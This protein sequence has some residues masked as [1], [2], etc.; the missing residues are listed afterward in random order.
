MA[1]ETH[2]DRRGGPTNPD[3]L[4]ELEAERSFLLRSLSDLDAEW[5]AGDVDEHDYV[6]LRDGYTKRAADVL[7]Q[8]DAGRA[9]LPAKRSAP[10]GRR[11]AAIAAVV[12]VGGVAGWLV[13]RSSG[14]RLPGQQL[15]GDA[16]GGDVAATLTQARMLLGT[17]PLRAVE[18]YSDV[19]EQRPDQAEAHTYRGW[20]LY[21]GSR[22]AGEEAQAQADVIARDDLAAAIESDPQYAD[23]HC[24]LAV[25]AANDDDTATAQDEADQC[26]ALDPPGEVRAL[27]DQFLADLPDT[28]DPAD[29]GS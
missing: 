10:W 2:V 23:P 1:A 27:M 6:T 4:A 9:R 16:P 22:D 8:I 14:Q 19:L 7:R 12:A 11:M 25:I 28:P 13:A 21:I 15:S 5:G 17:D 18:L 3:R 26:L 24:F 20:L 29:P